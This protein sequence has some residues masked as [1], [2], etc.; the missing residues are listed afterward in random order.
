MDQI[1]K[2]EKYEKLSDAEKQCVGQL[3]Y[4]LW[5]CT[6]CKTI[7]ELEQFG[8]VVLEPLDKLEIGIEFTLH[9][10]RDPGVLRARLQYFRRGLVG[11]YGENRCVEHVKALVAGRVDVPDF[12]PFGSI[13]DTTSARRVGDQ[14][15]F[16]HELAADFQRRYLNQW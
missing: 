10:N 2:D 13:D 9:P 8:R 7:D 14:Q 15:L 4:L 3:V 6:D 16:Y 1:K 5:E 12:P 11:R